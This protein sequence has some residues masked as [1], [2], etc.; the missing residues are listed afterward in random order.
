[1]STQVSAKNAYLI[2]KWDK[3][4][5]TTESVIGKMNIE[6]KAALATSLENTHNRLKM[7]EATQPSAIG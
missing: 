5:R 2:K 6:R 4:I 3:R 7:M 1:M